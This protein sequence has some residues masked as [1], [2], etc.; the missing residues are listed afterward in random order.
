MI[1]HS[2]WV[3]QNV[4]IRDGQFLA[5]YDW[6]SLVYAPESAVVGMVAS[7]FTQGSPEAPDAP[8]TAEVAEFIGD[9]ESASDRRFDP[10]EQ[11]TARAAATWTRCYNARCQLD[12]LTRYAL[13]PPTGSFL[14]HLRIE[15][16]GL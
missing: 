3:W 1:G 4:C 10:L 2:D 6:D 13:A 12:S 5:G 14:E 11:R 8:S 16:G 15:L 9:Y 7:S